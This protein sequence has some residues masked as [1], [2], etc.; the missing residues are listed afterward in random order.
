MFWN[1]NQYKSLERYSSA[2]SS[3]TGESE[4]NAK[5]P[6]K[7][8]DNPLESANLAFFHTRAVEGSCVGI[9]YNIGSGTVYGRVAPLQSALKFWLC[10]TLNIC[11]QY[12]RFICSEFCKRHNLYHFHKW[13][14]NRSIF[15][16]PCNSVQFSL[17]LQLFFLAP[18]FLLEVCIETWS[19]T[20]IVLLLLNLKTD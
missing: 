11:E 10:W 9:V 19:M 20:N 17:T 4:P 14:K 18:K 7:S 12:K 2:Q 8:H 6:E 5:S 15:L 13:K 1:R 16:M 3:L